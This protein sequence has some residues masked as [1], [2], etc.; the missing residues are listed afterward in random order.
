VDVCVC[1]CVCIC[2]CVCACACVRECV[3][4]CVCVCVFLCVCVCEC[5][6]VRLS[7]ALYLFMVV[8]F[9]SRS[10]F[11]S[12]SLSLL[13][14]LSHTRSHTLCLMHSLRHRYQICVPFSLGTHTYF[15]SF[16][17]SLPHSLPRTHS[18][19]PSPT[20]LPTHSLIALVCACS[21]FSVSR[22]FCLIFILFTHQLLAAMISIRNTPALT[23]STFFHSL[24]RGVFSQTKYAGEE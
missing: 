9:L 23:A 21:P 8:S 3:C 5:V 20:Y 2:A 17:L 7:L 19:T 6:C 4:V 10:R 15:L 18:R 22:W 11:L 24:A 13:H 1:A 16:A 14:I 12:L